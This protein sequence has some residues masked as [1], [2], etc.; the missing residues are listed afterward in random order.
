MAKELVVV[1]KCP[2][3][4]PLRQEGERQKGEYEMRSVWASADKVK[5]LEGCLYGALLVLLRMTSLEESACTHPV[6]A[7]VEVDL[8]P[9]IE[10]SISL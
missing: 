1:L 8:N 9:S 6:V 3:M 2:A 5:S 10:P 4:K 7:P